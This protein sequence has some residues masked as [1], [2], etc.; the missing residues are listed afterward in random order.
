MKI[1]EQINLFFS[2]DRQTITTEETDP[3]P[4]VEEERPTL[5]QNAATGGEAETLHRPN[6]VSQRPDGVF[7]DCNPGDKSLDRKRSPTQWSRHATVFI[8][9]T[10]R[11]LRLMATRTASTVLLANVEFCCELMVRVPEPAGNWDGSNDFYC[12]S[13]RMACRLEAGGL[14]YC[15]P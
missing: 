11:W 2:R 10:V 6:V 9:E 7:I 15:Q 12:R 4:T 13:A 3:R 1:S 8:M 5:V 14:M